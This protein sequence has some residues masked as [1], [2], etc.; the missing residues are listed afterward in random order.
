M[1]DQIK[2][3]MDSGKVVVLYFY[4]EWCDPCK[5]LAPIINEIVA[6]EEDVKLVKINIEKEM[7]MAQEHNIRS[8]P[9]LVIVSAKGY[10]L[11]VGTVPKERIKELIAKVR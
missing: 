1:K 6:E 11:C 5:A 2:E 9:T 7:D 10:E 3:A 4:A 8:V